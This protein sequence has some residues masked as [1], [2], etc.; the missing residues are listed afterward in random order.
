MT[1]LLSNQGEGDFQ[2]AAQEAAF[3]LS[4]FALAVP[5]A[6]KFY[7]GVIVQCIKMR[8]KGP[9]NRKAAA[10]AFFM[11]YL[12]LQS[13]L[14]KLLG[15]EAGD[16]GMAS[17]VAA[18]AA[19]L[20]NREAAAGAAAVVEV[21]SMF[22]A[23]A[24]AVI[25]GSDGP[26]PTHQSA[27]ILMQRLYRGNRGRDYAKQRMRALVVMQSFVR[28]LLALIHMKRLRMAVRIQA[29]QRGIAARKHVA[30]F[31]AVRQASWTAED[32]AFS[33]RPGFAWVMRQEALSV[34]KD[35]ID[36]IRKS[37]PLTASRMSFPRLPGQSSA[38]RQKISPQKTQPTIRSKPTDE[39][40][41]ESSESD[42]IAPYGDADTRNVRTY[43]S[44]A[45]LVFLKDDKPQRGSTTRS[46][47]YAVSA[48]R[49]ETAMRAIAALPAGLP[50]REGDDEVKKVGPQTSDAILDKLEILWEHWIK[51]ALIIFIGRAFVGTQTF[52]PKPKKQVGLRRAKS[53]ARIQEHNENALQIQRKKEKKEDDKVKKD[54][55]DDDD[56]GGDGGDG[57]D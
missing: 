53:V 5:L 35:R 38:A 20:A 24:Y 39:E 1:A 13:T 44:V 11:F 15:I 48:S 34:A 3:A 43:H 27:A 21:G 40:L 8:R 46:L 6:R 2:A 52:P 36:R 29:R 56:D 32:E 30:A 50:P 9:F 37:K 7:D 18:N 54:G 4:L 41:T 25:Y 10:L 12:Q 45:G 28:R 14:L 42:E 19:K 16:A 22:A 33:S 31:V 23:D 57:G 55:D 49:R 47:D 51:P 17:N 26:G